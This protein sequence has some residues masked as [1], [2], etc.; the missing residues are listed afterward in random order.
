MTHKVWGKL[1]NDSIK[2]TSLKFDKQAI[3]TLCETQLPAITTL[4]FVKSK[5]NY[6]YKNYSYVG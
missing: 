5:T 1:F 6:V 3:Y 4:R 2:I